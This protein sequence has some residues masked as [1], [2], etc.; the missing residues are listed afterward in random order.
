[1][2]GVFEDINAVRE[3]LNVPPPAPKVP[4]APIVEK[5]EPTPNLVRGA[6]PKPVSKP[7]VQINSA[8]NG[9]AIGGG[10]VTNPT[11]NN[12]GTPNR[13]L[14]P[15]QMGSIK[16]SAQGLCST[17]PLIPVTAA[18]ANQEAQRY[19][20][21]FVNAL[22]SGGCTADLALPIPGLMPDVVGVFVGVRDMSNLGS[23]AEALKHILSESGIPYLVAPLKPDF[24]S[25][26]Q[27]VLVIGAS[28]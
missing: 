21:D 22:R 13:R 24:F 10:N 6:A 2:F 8:P 23:M 20:L 15:Q 9:I 25:D 7:P 18:Q 27:M 14:T 4:P 17:L 3:A 1:M 5:Q 28:E 12:F 11:V 19:A 26:K 16:S